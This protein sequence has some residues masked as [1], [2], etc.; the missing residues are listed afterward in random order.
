VAHNIPSRAEATGAQH[1]VR[2]WGWVIIERDL[3]LYTAMRISVEVKG[4]EETF[5]TVIRGVTKQN[6]DGSDRQALVKALSPGEELKLVREQKNP[7]DKYAVAV[8]RASG[9]QLGYVPAGDRRLADHFDMGGRTF[10]KVVRIVGGPGILGLFFKS[11]RRPYGCVI[12]I[13]KHDFNWKEVTP[14]IDRSK[15][16]GELIKFARTLEVKDAAKAISMYREAIAQIVAFDKAGPVAAAWRRARYPIN[17]LTFLLEKSGH[18]RD[19]YDEILQ[20]ERFDDV[21]GL[22][23]E[24]EKSITAR[25][26]R[27]AKKLDFEDAP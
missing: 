15:E 2:C 16:I 10:A 11:F 24:E 14:Y 19:A 5:R 1:D 18:L 8:F 25:K 27:L 20:Y 17:R 4:Y 9:E 13:V 21:F 7:Y 22:T 26:R 6:T 12:E 23:S 3:G